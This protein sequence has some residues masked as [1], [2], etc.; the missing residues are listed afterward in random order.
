MTEEQEVWRPLGVDTD[1]DIAEYDA[2]HE[3]IP[4]WMAA[5]FRDWLWI[6]IQTRGGPPGRGP[7]LNWQL[8]VRMGQALRV[9]LPNMKDWQF[10]SRL[11]ICRSRLSTHAFPFKASAQMGARYQ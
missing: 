4:G 2:L 3:G 7:E 5:E 8:L 9:P 6:A 1:K 11:D 10:T